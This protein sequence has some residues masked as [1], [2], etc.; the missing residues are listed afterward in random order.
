[1]GLAIIDGIGYEVESKNLFANMS[2]TPNTTRKKIINTLIKQLKADNNWGF[3]D[4]LWITAAHSQQAAKLNWINPIKFTLT[5]VNSPTWMADKGYTGDGATSY[6][7]TNYDPSTQG[8]NYVL[9]SCCEAVYIR[10]NVTS[11]KNDIGHGTATVFS[12]I[13]S[14]NASDQIVTRLNQG[15]AAYTAANTNSTGFYSSRRTA[16]NAQAIFKNGV[17]QATS[18]T[19]SSSLINNNIY[20]CCSNNNG[21]AGSFSANEISVALVGGG[22]LNQLPLYVAIQNY[23]TAIGTQV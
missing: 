16:S 20:F 9:N 19:A 1:M 10:T 21:T 15:G 6:L 13:N 12:A 22:G 5:E 11:G 3:I 18:A 7:N 8:T 23:M 2:V 14:R 4:G 17:S